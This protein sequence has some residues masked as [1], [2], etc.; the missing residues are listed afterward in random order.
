MN[1]KKLFDPK[2]LYEIDILNKAYCYGIDIRFECSLSHNEQFKQLKNR[3]YEAITT[4]P[5]TSR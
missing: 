5:T 2:N 1:E 3:L 4:I